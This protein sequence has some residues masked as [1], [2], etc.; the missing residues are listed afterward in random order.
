MNIKSRIASPNL[1]DICRRKEVVLAGIT[2]NGS[3]FAEK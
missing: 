1:W 3:V 2:N